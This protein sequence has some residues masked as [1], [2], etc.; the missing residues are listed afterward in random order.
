[1]RNVCLAF[2]A[3]ALLSL[4]GCHDYSWH[5]DFAAPVDRG[6]NEARILAHAFTINSAAYAYVVPGELCVIGLESFNPASVTLRYSLATSVPVG[7][8]TVSIVDPAHAT[9]SFRP[10]ETALGRD[11]VFTVSVAGATNGY[12]YP[13]YSF[14]LPCHYP[15]GNAFDVTFDLPDATTGAFVLPLS[16]ASAVVDDDYAVGVAIG[17]ATGFDATGCTFAWYVDGTLQIGATASSFTFDPADTA[18]AVGD[19]IVSI[20]LSRGSSAWSANARITIRNTGP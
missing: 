12:A 16:P 13:D 8:V 9:I 18:W 7:P 19:H 17:P 15:E 1:M 3:C 11:I 5:A 14:T 2:V 4:A 6:L 10:D 20:V